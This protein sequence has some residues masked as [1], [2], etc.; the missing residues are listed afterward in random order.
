[1]ASEVGNGQVSIFPVFKGFRSKTN[2]EVD[3]AGREASS[4]FGKSF[5][6]GAQAAGGSGGKSFSS[7]FGRA[8]GNVGA[9][10]SKKLSANVASASKA[11]SRARL[12]EQDSAGKVKVAEAALAEARSKGADGSAR[13]VAAE[14][15]LASTQRKLAEAQSKTAT[16]SSQLTDAQGALADAT[17][18]AGSS[19][20][21][22][23]GRFVR[24]WAGLKAKLA[25]S[26]R[27]S[28]DGASE[29]AAARADAGGRE[30]GSRFGTA[31]KGALGALAAVFAV[32]KIKDFF[33]SAISG[34]GQLEQSVGAIESVFKG[35]AGQM[36]K[37]SKT[38]QNDVGLT[39]NEFNEL[40]T[41][42]GSQLKNGGTAMDQLAPQTNKLIGLG[43]DLSSMFGGSSREA[44]EAL[45]AAL[46]GERDP[47][48]RYGVSLNDAKIKAE[49]AALGFKAVGG[50]L[51]DEAKQAATLSLIMKQTA[52]AHGNFAKEANTF[53]G[54]KQRMAAGWVNI[55]SA[56]GDKFLPVLTLAATAINTHVLPAVA[57]LVDGI[58]FSAMGSKLAPFTALVGEVSGGVRAMVAAFQA[59][60]TDV[61]SSGLA[62]AFERVGLVA[63]AAFDFLGPMVADIAATFAPLVPQIL[64]LVTNFSPLSIIFQAIA[65]LLPQI[66]AMVSMLANMVGGLLA[67]LMPL[68]QTLLAQIVPVFTTL[69][70]AILPVVITLVT[71]LVSAFAPLIMTLVSS[72]APILIQ[73][74]STI[75]PIVVSAFTAILGAVMPVVNVLLAVLMPVIQALLP[76]I[77]TVFG[78]VATII[79]GVM[80]VIQGVIQVVTG[81]ISGNWSLVWDGIKNIFQGIWTAIGGILTGAWALI[82]G[83]ITAGLAVVTGLWN[84]AWTAIKTVFGGV[85]NGIKALLSGAIAAVVS[86]VTGGVNNVK[87]G[88]TAAW[89]AVKTTLSGAWSAITSS[90]SNGIGDVVGFFTGLP[91][92]ITGSLS[93]IAGKLAT[94]G[95]QMIQGLIG[96]IKDMAQ[97][98]INAV[99]DVVGGA[100][101]GAKALLGIASP[102]KVFKQFGRWVSEGLGIGVTESASKAVDAV[103]KLSEKVA[104]AGSDGIKAEAK[105]LQEE[106]RKANKRIADYNKSLGKKKQDSLGSI[107]AAEATKLAK[108]KLG[109]SASKKAIAAEAKAIRE[110]RVQAN[111]KI[112][113]DNKKLGGKKKDSLG[114]LSAADAEK[115]AKKNLKAQRA[116]AKKAQALINAQA[117]TTKAIWAKGAGAGTDRLLAALSGKGKFKRG[118]SK[119]LLSATITDIAKA[120]EVI[121]G[122]LEKANGKLKS[123]LEMQ[124]Q[125]QSS[126]MG[127]LDLKA[128]LG[129]DTQNAFGDTIKGKTTFASVAGQV[130]TLAAKTKV[131]A[132]K[133]KDLIKAGLPTGLVQEVAGY[134]TEAGTQVANALL[135]GSKQQMKDLSA[136]YS[137]LTKWSGEAGKHVAEDFY[138]I[139]FDA[140]RGLINGLKADDSKLKAAAKHLTDLLTKE[141]KKNLDTHSP[142]RVMD[143]EVGRMIP[144]GISQGVKK[145]APAMNRDI[146]KLVD[147]PDVTKGSKVLGMTVKSAARAAGGIYI[148]KIEISGVAPGTEKNV[149]DQLVAELKRLDRGGVMAGGKPR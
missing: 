111:K 138:G 101:N 31:F 86:T 80:Q 49:A 74:A 148:E 108:N 146:G 48:E 46:K 107:T 9:D 58:D 62:G 89:N 72:L 64:S 115:Q 6:K 135:S 137:S 70:Q 20:E 140:Q 30:S 103:K 3:G 4:R 79:T 21:Q 52:D 69:V 2:A 104:K 94:I 87:A 61:T 23:S 147:I 39:K 88:W 24:G 100:I 120:R 124:S 59:G 77:T 117:K 133:L 35:S 41:L 67:Q 54:Q 110:A 34:A 129:Q 144:A 102:S 118:T 143:R 40:G 142:S 109:A 10:A 33:G 84:G 68:A 81:V 25:G 8:A 116:G 95:T 57:K 96:G 5:A 119:D 38:A 130:K 131:F 113:A 99:G 114:S 26:M 73:L 132:G 16:S 112:A 17:Q 56:I 106:R 37:W 125:V 19:S 27:S 105:R 145:A 126:L 91:G 136:D 75:L 128:G 98:A 13:V 134:G 12:A 53:E 1:M 122:R 60:G 36:A 7:A 85:W 141:V 76:V 22:A 43:A 127:E 123:M 29:Q 55:K 63:R 71:T 14:E 90:V 93:D 82:Q 65:P 51:S 47:I 15:R 50:N 139:G 149:V 92:K 121:A 44:V 18:D 45:S 83:V 11:L 78:A 42:I 66:G 32:D 97:S 28:V